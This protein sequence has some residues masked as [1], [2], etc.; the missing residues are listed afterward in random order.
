LLK[1]LFGSILYKGFMDKKQFCEFVIKMQAISKIGLLFSKDEYALDNYRQI[2]DLSTKMLESFTNIEFGRPNYFKRDIYPTPNVSTRVFIFNEK[3]QIL[4]VKEAKTGTYSIPGGWC[5]LYDTPSQAARAEVLQ[6]A[7][8]EVKINRLIG[9][10]DRTPNVT[11]PEYVIAFEA[12]P[13]SGFHQLGYET[14]EARY[15]DVD[16]LPEMSH[17]LSLKEI[18]RLI[19]A[20]RNQ[21]TIFD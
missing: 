11:I 17:K 10:I 14:T 19:E 8:L 7:G 15:F 2:N 6:E 21:E 4:L 16:H 20:C 12:V 3:G 5:D 18:H 1:E 13:I 9:I